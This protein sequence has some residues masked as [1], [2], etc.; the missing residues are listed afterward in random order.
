M[1]RAVSWEFAQRSP[2]GIAARGG[3]DIDSQPD[4]EGAHLLVAL[5]EH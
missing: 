5:P 1:E 3:A 2:R 4:L